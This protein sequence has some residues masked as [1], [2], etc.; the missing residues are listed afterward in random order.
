MELE[1]KF[2]LKIF[3]Y[4]RKWEVI[5]E[6]LHVAPCTDHLS[7]FEQKNTSQR[8]DR[9]LLVYLQLW[10]H[11]YFHVTGPK[12]RH[13]KQTERIKRKFTRLGSDLQ[14]VTG[15]RA[16]SGKQ[17]Q[18]PAGRQDISNRLSEEETGRNGCQPDNNLAKSI[19]KTVLW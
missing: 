15:K 14:L 11:T 3:D 5:R 16:G 13:L 2:L 7:W 18:K 10:Q 12:S 1:E 6:Y 9:N 8:A 17:L 19:W 4:Y